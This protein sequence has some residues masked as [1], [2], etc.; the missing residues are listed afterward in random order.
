MLPGNAKK[1]PFQ[2]NRI[3]GHFFG[4]R[5]PSSMEYR[6]ENDFLLSSFSCQARE[7]PPW[8]SEIRA[9]VQHMRI[10]LAETVSA[11]SRMIERHRDRAS[12]Q[13]PTHRADVPRALRAGI[14]CFNQ[15]EHRGTR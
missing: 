3:N 6:G 8:N 7:E 13:K 2:I 1:I 10:D 9:A 14:F 5:A 4:A 12:F 11:F 15:T